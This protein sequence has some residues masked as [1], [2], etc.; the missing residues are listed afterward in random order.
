MQENPQNVPPVQ[1]DSFD[2]VALLKGLW[3]GRKTIIITFCVF[4]VLGLVAALTMKRTYSVTTVMFP[5][6]SSKSSSSL[7]SL[8]SLAGVNLS[9]AS[10]GGEIPA[11]AY[12]QIVNSV[13]YRLELIHTPLHFEK[14]D[15][16]VSLVEYATEYA[17]PNLFGV[18]KKYTIGLPSVIMG[19]LRKEKVITLPAGSGE[20]D[21]QKPLVLTKDE[22]KVLENL[23]QNISLSV[24][25]KEGYLTLSVVGSEPLQTAELA[26]KAQ[27]LL[28]EEVTRLGTEKAQSELE[29]IQARYDEIKAEAES[30]QT[31]LAAATDRSQDLASNRS[32]IARDRIQSKYTL[33]NSIYNDMA[34]QLEMAKMQVKK[35]TP[36]YTILQPVVVPSKPSN[37]R[38]KTLAMWLFMGVVVGCGIVMVRMYYPKVKEK[39]VS[40]A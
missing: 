31:A 33:A 34:R 37:S 29:Y 27:Q 14:I 8:A 39:F 2:Y 4:M 24:D 32:R 12:P 7:S 21:E 17:R 30:Y 36:V 25:K 26:L 19:A 6:M 13:P 28:Q 10:A 15:K 16:P 9:S 18:I 1:E 40:A 11:L 3:A 38:A 23:S 22:Q 20:E 5:Q 35:D